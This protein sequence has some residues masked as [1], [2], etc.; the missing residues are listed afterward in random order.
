MPLSG[1][2]LEERSHISSHGQVGGS[3][4]WELVPDEGRHRGCLRHVGSSSA[5]KLKV[6]VMS[7]VPFSPIEKR[8]S[9][10][11][12]LIFFPIYRALGHPDVSVIVE[13]KRFWFIP[14]RR[15]FNL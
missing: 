5:K 13:W 11:N 4:Q 1:A 14:Q 12:D 9:H 3:I 10:P 6:T 15:V 7:V 8:I 2:K